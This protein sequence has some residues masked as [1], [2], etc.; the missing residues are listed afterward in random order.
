[1]SFDEAARVVR[2]RERVIWA[3]REAL[4]ADGLHKSS[5][6]HTSVSFNLPS[7]FDDDKSHYWG[8]EIYSYV[9]GPS[10]NHSWFGKTLAEALAKAEAAVD[11]WCF[12]YEMQAFERSVEHSSDCAV[13]STP[14]CSCGF[15]EQRR[16]ELEDAPDEGD[17]ET[18]P[19]MKHDD[20]IA[21]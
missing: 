18:N 12:R 21:F 4:K 10:R 14:G 7:M 8:V 11:K 1:M 9:I 6:A 19:R 16:E 3:T 20:D 2:L 15:D 5:E 17:G 13:H